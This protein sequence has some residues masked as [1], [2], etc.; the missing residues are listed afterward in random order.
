MGT[1]KKRLDD[2]LSKLDPPG[3]L[4]WFFKKHI[5]QIGIGYAYFSMMLTGL[6]PMRDDVKKEIVKF[7]ED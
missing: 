6:R 2:K 5:A 1:M 3:S 4:L 7:L